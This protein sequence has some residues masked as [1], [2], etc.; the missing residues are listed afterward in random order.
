MKISNIDGFGDRGIIIDDIDFKNMSDEQWQEI[1][2]LHLENLVTILRNVKNL[3]PKDQWHWVSKWGNKRHLQD[4]NLF[5]KYSSKYN[6][7]SG[8]D[9]ARLIQ[10]V[11]KGEIS[12]EPTD[13]LVL[14]MASRMFEQWE[15]TYTLRVTPKK[16]KDGNPLGMFAE[17]ELLWHSNEGA[18]L[19]FTPGVSLYGVEGVE[20]TST[21][22]LNTADYYYNLPESFRNELDDM[23]VVHKFT[24]GKINPGLNY[25]QDEVMHT[26]MCPEDGSKVPLVIQNPIGV[27]GLHYPIN[28]V[29]HIEGMSK[30]ES[31]KLFERINKELFTDK[32]I[33]DHWYRNNNDNSITLHRRLGHNDDRLCYRIQHDYYDLYDHFWQPYFQEEYAN[34]YINDVKEYLKD[35]DM[36]GFNFKEAV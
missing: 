30:E 23:I 28:T 9:I 18:N 11:A 10:L 5:K 22:F 7:K 26:N 27:K 6:I 21:G 16:D 19:N 34:K 32:Y 4:H 20:G 29:D 31:D 15:E 36:K 33:Y 13:E 12:L 1:G 25:E 8:K 24:P 35:F 14:K 2:R 3:H 17:G